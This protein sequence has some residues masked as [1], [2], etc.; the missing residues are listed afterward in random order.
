LHHLPH[1]VICTEAGEKLP[2]F[3]RVVIQQAAVPNLL[4][5]TMTMPL[6]VAQIAACTLE[7]R[8]RKAGAASVVKVVVSVLPT[9]GGLE[10]GLGA[11][12]PT[13]AERELSGSHD[14]A[15]PPPC[16]V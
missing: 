9:A 6:S 13:A 10:E 3:S 16:L 15:K 1:L 7:K 4:Y 14:T 8:L 5:C 2:P 12:A 11:P